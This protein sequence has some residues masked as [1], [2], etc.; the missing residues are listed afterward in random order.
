MPQRVIVCDN[1]T[2]YVKAGFAGD[3]FPTAFFPSMMGRPVLRAGESAID[4]RAAS[5]SAKDLF[6][7]DEAAEKRALL[8]I[9]YPIENGVIQNWD[10][11][12]KLW[13]YTFTKKLGLGSKADFGDSRILLT[14]APMNPKKNRERMAE[15]MFEQF[16]F[17]SLYVSIQ[18][19]LT[20]YAQG[21]Q[22][23]VVVD[24][25]DGVTHIVPVYQGFEMP[26]LVKR[27]DIAGRDITRQLNRLL[28]HRGYSFNS[29]ADFDLVREMK[30]KLCY[31]GYEE[32]SCIFVM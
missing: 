24:S 29:T 32:P 5:G 23:G 7:G 31:V 3:N 8:D 11:T 1:G 19:V 4:G 13:E 25:G 10:D 17:H 30:E 15:V 22:T 28:F 2:G 20:L 18:A 26:H 14:E 9:S 16:G 6:I 12:I 21:L 27:L